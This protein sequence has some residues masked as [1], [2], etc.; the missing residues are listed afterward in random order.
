MARFNLESNLGDVAQEAG[1][2][3]GVLGGPLGRAVATARS[4]F[5]AL[6]RVVSLNPY[7]AL[8]TAITAFV[9]FI[10]SRFQPVIDRVQSAMAALN[11]IGAQTID[12][13]GS[14]LGLTER[15]GMSLAETAAAAYE[16]TRAEQALADRQI[17]SL[18]VQ[19]E[20]NAQ[21][22]EAQA[23]AADQTLTDEERIA[24]LEEAQRLNTEI[25]NEERSQAAERVR[26]LEEQQRLSSNTREDNEELARLRATLINLDAQ[27]SQMNRTLLA[28]RTALQRRT[29]MQAE[30]E[31]ARHQTHPTC[32]LY[33]SPSPRDS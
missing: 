17:A 29:E 23:I 10:S 33:T 14:L 25:F 21:L 26:I 8:V 32:L 24:A 28:Q 20:R 5:A 16:L 6:N 4:G 19:A 2:L 13:F 9:A 1:D 3:A 22:R 18:T 15:N 27:E 31:R 12:F 7:V 30:A 11:A